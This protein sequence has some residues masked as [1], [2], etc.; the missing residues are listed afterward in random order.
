MTEIRLPQITGST[1]KE[2]LE[3]MKTYMF[4]LTRDLNFAL[5]DVQTSE[6]KYLQSS[7]SGDKNT[8]QGITG[9]MGDT[10]QGIAEQEQAIETFFKLKRLIIKSADIIN[11]Y[12]EEINKKLKS[13]YL[14]SS[15]FGTFLENNLADYKI[16]P[17]FAQQTLDSFKEIEDTVNGIY[18][19]RKD[20]CYIKT[21]WLDDDNTI[22][23]VEIGKYS[24]LGNNVIDK[25]FARLTTDG[26]IFYDS[27]G[28]DEKD[29]TKNILAMFAKNHS[30]IRNL[31]IVDDVDFV[32]ADYMLETKNGLAFKWAGDT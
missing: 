16:T 12:Y 4:Q 32:S 19:L 21:G 26:L 10:S 24:E 6:T 2:Q 14:A 15:D 25:G 30:Y 5:K 31:Q 27:D 1:E 3:Q 17:E 29:K 20:S 8:S 13:V 11:A 18:A 9:E 22:A 23:G 7:R 28:V